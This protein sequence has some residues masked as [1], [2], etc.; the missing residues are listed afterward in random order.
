MSDVAAIPAASVLLLRDRPLRVLMMHRHEK[1]SFV[2]NVWVFPGGAVEQAD[3]RES[4][5]ETM[6]FAAA[7]ETFEETGIWLGDETRDFPRD[8]SVE[9]LMRIAPLDPER[10]VWTSHWITP[11]GVPMRYDT[12]FFLF[13]TGDEV[14]DARVNRE[15]TDVRWVT[16]PEAIEAHK[17]GTFPLVFPTLKNLE[18]IAPFATADELIA[19]RRGAH[20]EAIQPLLV[21][22]GG[23]KKIVLP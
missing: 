5:L 1:S 4:E 13:R 7:R 11:V 20:I 23:R 16:P 8:A 15:A 18:A 9:E 21:S 12:W 22:E 19:T 17:A 6:R 10:L 3:R 2:P 14:I